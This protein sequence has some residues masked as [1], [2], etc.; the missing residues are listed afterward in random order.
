MLHNRMITIQSALAISQKYILRSDAEI[1]LAYALKKE[2]I[3]L[4]SHNTDRLSF[5]SCF[6]FIFFVI[7]RLLHHPIAY[8][9]HQKEFFGYTFFVNKHTLIPRPETECIIE[10]IINTHTPADTIIDIGTGSGAIAISLKKQ[11]QTATVFATDISQ[12]A[13]CVAKKNARTLDTSIDFIKSDLL[14]DKK[15]IEVIKSQNN[16]IITA[17]LPYLTLQEATTEPSIK[18]EPLLALV[19]DNNGLALYK[20][21]L[22]QLHKLRKTNYTIYMEINDHQKDALINII[23]NI[24]NFE[25]SV[26]K[27]LSGKNRIVK[28]VK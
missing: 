25:I 5:V 2:K 7:K 9:T 19:A 13:L 23:R 21:L 8:I 22:E 14:I 6:K 12:R 1:L 4:I 27:D 15:I 3:F 24:S 28:V 16:L 18:K 11:I 26:I 20:K 10:D 17:N